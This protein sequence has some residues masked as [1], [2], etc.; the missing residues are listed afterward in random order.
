MQV[1]SA[2]LVGISYD[3]IRTAIEHINSEDLM[4]VCIE[5]LSENQLSYLRSSQF[6]QVVINS[7]ASEVRT[8]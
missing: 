7:T 2:Y 5:L 6:K 4:F 3:D 1:N 8:N